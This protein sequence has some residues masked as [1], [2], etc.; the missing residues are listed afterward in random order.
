MCCGYPDHLDDEEYK[1]ADPDSYHRLARHVDAMGLIRFPLKMRIVAMALS[2]ESFER[3]SV[4]FGSV[5]ARSHI[6]TVDEVDAHPLTL[7][8]I[9]RERLVVA[10]DC[11]LGLLPPELA[12]AR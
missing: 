7:N 9:D 6:E 11:G 4:I 2:C 10:P 12:E 3:M 1:K 5:V 8:H